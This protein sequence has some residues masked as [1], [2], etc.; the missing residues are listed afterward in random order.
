LILKKGHPKVGSGLTS[1]TNKYQN[2][3]KPAGDK[4]S[5]LF[6][7]AIS[8][9]GKSFINDST[10]IVVEH[11]PHKP[12]VKGLS[13]ATVAAD[14]MERE[15]EKCKKSFIEMTQNHQL[16]RTALLRKKIFLIKNFEPKI[17]IL[18]FNFIKFFSCLL[19]S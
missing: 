1:L 14:D 12:K 15:R 8:E 17:V 18:F 13:L 11:S 10:C 4:H 16:L 6:F 7:P 3:L 2:S 9:E 19:H 5:S